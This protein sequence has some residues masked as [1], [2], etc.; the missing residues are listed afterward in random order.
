MFRYLTIAAAV[1]AANPAAAQDLSDVEV[2]SQKL[3]PGVAVLFGAGGNIGVSYGADATVT[4]DDQ[5]APLSGRI[6]AAIA[7]LEAS[8]VEFV[9]NTH[10]HGD[11][12]GGNEH[13]GNTGATILAHD[14]VRV[15]MSR[16]HTRS[17]GTVIDPSP[18][19]AL[20]VV[21]YERGVTLHLNG[22]TI[23]IIATGGGH[24][25]GDSIIVWREKN[26]VHMGDLYFNWMGWPFIDTLS[27]GN[28]RAL[29]LSLDTALLMMDEETQVIPGHGEMS[30]KAELLAYRLLL[31]EAVDRI[32]AL[33]D[34]G[35]TLEQVQSAKPLAD[36]G[37][38]EGFVTTDSFIAAVWNGLD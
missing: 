30:T 12:T 35:S 10:W 25:D 8:P 19:A 34:S 2:T 4:I 20:P 32:A 1:L 27:G 5:F 13:F 21:T 14:N 37:R 16:P 6:E 11:H 29:L 26:V 36:M 24:T 31:G 23:D 28:I 22:D 17:S 33:K 9:V 3:A 7:G 15:R 18:P 38:T